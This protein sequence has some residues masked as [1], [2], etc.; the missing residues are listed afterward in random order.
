MR[1]LMKDSKDG[2]LIV[3][4]PTDVT[5]DP[6]T[7]ELCVYIATG[8]CYLVSGVSHISADEAITQLFTEGTLSL[9]SYGT[10]YEPAGDDGVEPAKGAESAEDA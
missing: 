4:S 6:E 3:A 2:T 7:E 10:T 5:Y 1:V 8:D 9:I